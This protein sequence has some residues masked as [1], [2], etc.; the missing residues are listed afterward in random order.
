MY[1]LRPLGAAC[2]MYKII[3]TLIGFIP[4]FLLLKR[5]LQVFYLPVRS[6]EVVS[7]L[8]LLLNRV[9]VK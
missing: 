8:Q 3:P 1:D 5:H 6:M 2:A 9:I 4:R 7:P